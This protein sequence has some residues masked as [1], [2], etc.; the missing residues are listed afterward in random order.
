MPIGC[1]LHCSIILSTVSYRLKQNVR[2]FKLTETFGVIAVAL[3]NCRLLLPTLNK[4]YK[5]VEFPR[6]VLEFL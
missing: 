2:H 5:L 3:F 6:V 1:H 4:H